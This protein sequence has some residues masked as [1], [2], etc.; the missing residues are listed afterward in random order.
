MKI[1]FETKFHEAQLA[2]YLEIGIPDDKKMADNILM[3]KSIIAFPENMAKLTTDLVAARIWKGKKLLNTVLGD[4]V[5]N[6]TKKHTDYYRF[7]PKFEIKKIVYE[8]EGRNPDEYY[9]YYTCNN[10]KKL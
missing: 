5:F 8:S 6:H 1:I 10:Y 4:W 3:G 7:T 9:F 2:L